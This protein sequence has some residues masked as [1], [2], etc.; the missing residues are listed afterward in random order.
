VSLA[1]TISDEMDGLL[2]YLVRGGLVG[3]VVGAN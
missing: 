1:V 2:T 3:D